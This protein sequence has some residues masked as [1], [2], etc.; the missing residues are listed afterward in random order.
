MKNLEGR[1]ALVTGAAKGIGKAIALKLAAE[2]A[3][4]IVNYNGSREKAEETLAEIRKISPESEIMQCDVSDYSAV[5]EMISGIVKKSGKLDILVNNAGITKDSLLI[6][7]KEE[8]F[9]PVISINLKGC[10]NCMQAASKQMV[11]QR[12][13]HIVNIS[14]FVGVHGNAG[15]VNYAASKAGIIGMTKSAAKELGS[16]GITV[17]AVAPGFI[18]TDMTKVLSEKIRDAVKEQIPMKEFGKPEDVAELVAFLAGDN[19]R[20][21]TGQVIGI[22]GGLE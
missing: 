8:Q 9:D 19:S 3:V 16:R 18:E 6:G 17:N 15:Q 7:M 2:G 14:S 22:D 1:I 4:L 12:S 20:Y 10:F 13:G 11:R 5:Q 21:I